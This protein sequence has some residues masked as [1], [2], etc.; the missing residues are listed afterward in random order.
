MNK[1]RKC[2]AGSL[3]YTCDIEV[4]SSLAISAEAEKM[5]VAVA[6]A[7]KEDS[8]TAAQHETK[9]MVDMFNDYDINDTELVYEPTGKFA[10]QIATEME[11]VFSD[12][13]IDELFFNELYELGK[14]CDREAN[15][16]PLEELDSRTLHLKGFPVEEDLDLDTILEFF[17]N[18]M[19]VEHQTI[20]W[21]TRDND[22]FKGSVFA[23][24]KTYEQA[25]EFR[26][27]YKTA[28]I[29]SSHR[30]L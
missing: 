10:R 12:P 7:V 15:P 23:V 22:K 30:A 2:I 13:F 8:A 25:M 4:G 19:A 24:F 18:I 6:A 29:L 21:Y 27:K 1:I 14:C 20:Y 5:S 16:K 11:F 17:D 26:V 3:K 28:G 9:S